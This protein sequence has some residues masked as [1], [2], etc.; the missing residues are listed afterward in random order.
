[1]SRFLWF[2]V[3]MM[4]PLTNSLHSVRLSDIR[5]FHYVPLITTSR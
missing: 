3:Y 4:H 5:I 1:M 2:T